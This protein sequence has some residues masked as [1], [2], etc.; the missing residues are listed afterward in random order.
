MTKRM[1]LIAATAFVLAILSLAAALVRA[2]EPQKRSL[3]RVGVYDS[4]AVAIAYY[5]S[6]NWSKVLKE[7]QAELEQAKKDGDMEKVKEIEAWGPAHQAKAH[8]KGFGTAP[9]HDCLDYIK[10][11]V[12]AVAKVAGVDVIVSKWEFDYMAAD[13]EVKDITDQMVALYN[14]G[15]KQLT[16]IKQLQDVAPLS[17]EEILKHK[18]I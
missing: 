9:V 17:E 18:D 14:P 16:C 11:R 7:K 8:L 4:R 3:L 6:D 12:P 1:G 13:A 5:N 10:D 15:E 2:G